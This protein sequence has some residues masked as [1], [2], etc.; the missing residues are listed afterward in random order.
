M[1]PSARRDLGSPSSL[2]TFDT[3]GVDHFFRSAFYLTVLSLKGV[4]LLLMALAFC[5]VFHYT[6][7]E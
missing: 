1:V 3:V 6:P 5:N 2:T 4:P 7:L